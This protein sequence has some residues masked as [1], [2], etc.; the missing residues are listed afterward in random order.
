MWSRVLPDDTLLQTRAAPAG[1]P[2][3]VCAESGA[4]NW[5]RRLPAS[6]W[7]ARGLRIACA[8]LMVGRDQGRV[9]GVT[10]CTFRCSWSSVVTRALPG[11]PRELHVSAESPGW[12]RASQLTGAVEP[13]KDSSEPAVESWASGSA[14][15]PHQHEGPVSSPTR[16]YRR[17]GFSHGARKGDF[18]SPRDWLC[19]WVLISSFPR[20][21]RS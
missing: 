11:V 8:F 12:I 7:T 14:L 13:G 9:S 15:I 3:G 20:T 16:P 21:F 5:V 2:A 1:P 4:I 18:C 17:G 10:R 19:C 6:S